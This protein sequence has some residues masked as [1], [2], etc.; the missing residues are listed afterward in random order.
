VLIVQHIGAHQSVLPD[1]LSKSGP[2]PARHAVDGAPL[3]VSR[4]YVAPPDHHMLVVGHALRLTRGPKEHHARP[5]VDPLFL[6]AA[7]ARGPDVVGVVLTGYLDD[8]TAGLQAIK[9]CGGTAV[10]QDPADASVPGMP[11]SAL[12][13]VEVDHCVTVAQLPGLLT[14]LARQAPTHHE[15]RP[16]ERLLHELDLT[17]AK[18]IAMEHLEQLGKTSNY[19]CPDCHGSLWE[20]AGSEPKRYRCHTGHGYTLRSLQQTLALAADEAIWNALRAL[21]EKAMV[22]QHM[23]LLHRAGGDRLLADRIEAIAAE[24]DRQAEALRALIEATP[25]LVD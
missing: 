11:L 20:V 15:R 21:E 1:I 3:E 7:L 17:L 5:A 9:H 14:S 24:V 13:H 8:G 19:T 22:L 12:Q 23:A 16:A 2:L 6:S 25:E 4:I 18:G 10:V